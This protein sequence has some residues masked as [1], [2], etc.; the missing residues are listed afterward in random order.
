MIPYPLASA[1][2]DMLMQQI[3][4]PLMPLSV[5]GLAIT[6]AYLVVHHAKKGALAAGGIMQDRFDERME[7][8]AIGDFCEDCGIWN[9]SWELDGNAGKCTACHPP[10]VEESEDDGEEEKG[11]EVDADA[12]TKAMIQEIID[13]GDLALADTLCNEAGIDKL[14]LNWH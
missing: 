7:Q 10:G 9:A 5:V 14:S 11:L 3:V 6:G 12:H 8:N 13:G 2:S 1:S 4:T